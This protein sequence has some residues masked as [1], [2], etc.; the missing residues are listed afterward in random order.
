MPSPSSGRCNA[1][2][3]TRPTHAEHVRD[4]ALCGTCH[5]LFTDA[6]TAD[7]TATGDVLPEQTPYLEWRNSAY[8]TETEKP[9]PLAATCQAC[10]L[11][12]TDV[13]DVPIM[14]KI[15]HNPGGRDFPP[16]RP[17]LPYGRHVLVGGN[18]LVPS[19]LDDQRQDLRPQATEEAFAATL[20]EAKTQ[21]SRAADLS[22]VS[23]ER[24]ADTLA[25]R[26]RVENRSGHRLPTGHPIRRMWLAVTVTDAAGKTV[27]ASGA[28]DEQGRILGLGGSV[29]P[30]EQA[31]GPVEPHRDLVRSPDEVA[32]FQA[33]MEDVEGEPDLAP[34]PRSAVPARRPAPSHG[35]ARRTGP[36]RR[37]SRLGAS[38]GTPTSWEGPTGSAT[39]WRSR[40]YA[41]GPL[42]LEARLC[43]QVLGARWA[44]E[45][46]AYETPE[47]E[48]LRRY[49]QAADRRPVVIVR[50]EAE[51]P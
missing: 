44:A 11:P 16:I 17:R 15:A 23:A 29:L 2:S 38:K 45:L 37:R 40:A 9:G 28:S 43:Y 12:T 36:T 42:R 47:V 20:E 41:E 10:H 7:G 5:T 31:G 1:T 46:L 19:M 21:L 18:T 50:L 24:R 34:A 49:L 35:L 8:T 39:R 6:L 13:D 25:L 4:S 32:L 27:F 14:T 22:L 33:R 51:I 3:T 30:S 26:L 48:A